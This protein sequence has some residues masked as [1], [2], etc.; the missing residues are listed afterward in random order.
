MFKI[1]GNADIPQKYQPLKVSK[2]V[3]T[4]SWSSASEMTCA[5]WVLHELCILCVVI[6]V[7]IGALVYIFL[8]QDMLQQIISTS[9]EKGWGSATGKTCGFTHC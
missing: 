1:S 5:V 2:Y 9:R 8:L 7:H 4:L 6:Y 3:G